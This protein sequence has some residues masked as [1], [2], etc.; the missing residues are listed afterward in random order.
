MTRK[1]PKAGNAGK[2]I[3]IITYYW[4]PAGGPGVQRW[5]KFVKYLGDFGFNPVVYIP[6]NPS[7]PIRDESMCAE[8]P[9]NIQVVK[10]SIFE[11]YKW[12]GSLSKKDTENIS[13][14]LI[15]DDKKQT[16][17][18]KILL[19]IRGNFFIPDARKFWVKPSIAFLSKF[20]E[21]EKIETII[22]TG[23]PH[24]L[25][26]IGLGLKEKLG[27][28]WV[29]DFRDPWTNIGYQ[30]K[31]KLTPRSEKKHKY[32]ERKV[33]QSADQI[34]TTSFATKE[35]F[36]AITKRPIE[37]I[38]NGF[39]TEFSVTEKIDKQFTV[40]H[41]GSLLSGRNPKNLWQVFA[42]LIDENEAFK[43][44]F[45]LRLIGKVSQEVLTSIEATGL[46]N[47]VEYLGYV[48]HNEALKFQQKSQVL[49]LLEINSPKTRGIIP[50][51]L[52]EYMR[53]QRPIL[54]IGPD[55]WD[56][57][58]LISKTQTGQC[59]L[60]AEKESIKTELCRFF[61]KYQAGELK[62]NP[63]GLMC[64]TRKALTEQLS[65]VLKNIS[66]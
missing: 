14:G 53:S 5:L 10:R 9:K 26:L 38:T 43:E 4:P 3:L 48:S 57:E 25:H 35:E 23:P 19:H 28:K 16:V 63:V 64:Y 66:E 1:A 15:E 58:K 11:P 49:L 36:Q 18:Q 17:L 50:G 61:E 62:T 47:H 33:L 32:L 13:S 30:E 20:L 2:K 21:D 6:E 37:V 40:A 59:F 31:L 56:V 52:F 7:Y 24:S 34:L 12:A 42:E 60:Y 54:A 46:K 22:S 65:E 29:A 27:V 45:R 44:H 39:D 55:Q 41:I 51:K 8:V